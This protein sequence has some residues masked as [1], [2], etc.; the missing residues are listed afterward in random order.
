MLVLA[1][2]QAQGLS[3]IKFNAFSA[4]RETTLGS[5]MGF[6]AARGLQLELSQTTSSEQQAQELLDG[7]WDITGADADNYVYWTQDHGADFFIFMV[8]E[9]T[10]DNHLWV[11]R[12]ITSFE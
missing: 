10:T 3:T 1:P 4:R 5:D 9:G 6:F 12:E 7:V 11:R 2:L 8:G